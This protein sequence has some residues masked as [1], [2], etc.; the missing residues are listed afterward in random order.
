MSEQ[1]FTALCLLDLSVAFDT[2]DHSILLHR[3]SSWFGF[4]G[5][6][7]TWHTS[8]LPSRSF[9]VFI[10]SI[11]SAQSPLRQG[12]P[13]GSVLGSLLFILYTTPLSS[14]I[15]NSLNIKCIVPFT[16]DVCISAECR[17]LE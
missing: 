8:Y 6:V 11:S 5:T 2:I 17:S 14:L 15:S 12:V 16:A 1:K 10:N 4:D 3:L 13:Q 9:V 7:I